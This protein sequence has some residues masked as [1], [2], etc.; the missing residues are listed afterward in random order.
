MLWHNALSTL[1][2]LYRCIICH[3]W[4]SLPIIIHYMYSL[5]DSKWCSMDTRFINTF[6]KHIVRYIMYKQ[7]CKYIK[8]EW[9]T[10]ICSVSSQKNPGHVICNILIMTW[11]NCMITLP[12]KCIV[13][14]RWNIHELRLLRFRCPV[15]HV[16]WFIQRVECPAISDQVFKFY[17]PL[18]Y[19]LPHKLK[20]PW[21]CYMPCVI[22]STQKASGPYLNKHYSACMKYWWGRLTYTEST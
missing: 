4:W 8:S 22:F 1:D 14:S 2:N 18:N 13:H 3:G 7:R 19:P 11:S 12:F 9:I 20:P 15:V 21:I 10:L 6:R 17:H 5:C 16:Q